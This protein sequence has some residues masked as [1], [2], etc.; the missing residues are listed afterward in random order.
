[1]K[2][3]IPTQTTVGM[4]GF[5]RL[6]KTGAFR[7]PSRSA[8]F[9]VRRYL[10]LLLTALI[11]VGLL[12]GCKAQRPDPS[13]ADEYTVAQHLAVGDQLY[14]QGRVE[15]AFTHY[16]R[17][18]AKDPENATARFRKGRVLS[19]RGVF[20]Q[21][22]DEYEAVLSSDP[23]NSEA[24]YGAG[25]CLYRSG[26]TEEAR[27]YFMQA[28]V[29]DAS[30]WEAGVYLGIIAGEQ[31]RFEEAEAAFRRAMDVRPEEL[32][33]LNGLGVVL[34][35]SG[36]AGESLA[37]LR[38]A[39]ELGGGERVANNLGMA[40]CRLGQYDAALAVFAE[41]VGEAA[42]HNN[43][44]WCLYLEGK[45]DKAIRHFERAIEL[46]PV[47][48]VRAHENLQRAKLSRR[49]R[50]DAPPSDLARPSATVSPLDRKGAGAG[51]AFFIPTND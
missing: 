7:M 42:A 35:H 28:S 31:G 9:S 8:G 18:A 11:A 29:A 39:L 10:P 50:K 27:S 44:G 34:M 6:R 3:V 23:G 43:L 20:D 25:M 17:A 47:F 14:R 19:S 30:M 48:Y 22:L 12:G 32:A 45:Y 13:V 1:M 36:R 46:S 33:V 4:R 5:G 38:R 24:L 49:Y 41:A 21:A 2:A 37:P 40:Y 26:L 51:K 16:A 15:A